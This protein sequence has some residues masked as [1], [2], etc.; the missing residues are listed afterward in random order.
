MST[1]ADSQWGVVVV[2]MGLI[3]YAIGYHLARGRG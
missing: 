1:L 3:A 2:V